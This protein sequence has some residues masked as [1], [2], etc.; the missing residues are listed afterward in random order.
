MLQNSRKVTLKRHFQI[1]ESLYIIFRITPDSKEIARS[2]VKE[3]EVY[4]LDIGLVRGARDR[5]LRTWR[6]YCLL[7]HAYANKDLLGRPCALHYLRTKDSA[8]V[9]FL[10]ATDDRPELLVEIKRSDSAPARTLINCSKRY[11]I[12]G[13][14]MVL[15]LRREKEEKGIEIRRRIDFLSSLST[16]RRSS[17]RMTENSCMYLNLDSIHLR[18]NHPCRVI[19]PR[20]RNGYVTPQQAARGGRPWR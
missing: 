9:D 7:K 3:P 2:M 19:D 1:L 17:G 6:P 16:L 14:Q 15:H 11:D 18:T 12:P 10:L 13:V 5:G 20:F 4:F 8:E